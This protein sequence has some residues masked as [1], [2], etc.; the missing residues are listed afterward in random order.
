MPRLKLISIVC[1]DQQDWLGGDEPYLL[2]NGKRVWQA[3][4]VGSGAELSL[5]TVHEIRFFSTAKVELYEQDA[6]AAE[7]EKSAS[8]D[9]L[10]EW[11]VGEN[12]IGKGEQALD[13]KGQ[14]GHYVLKFFV[15]P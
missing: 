14:G 12:L 5:E 4:G 8:D 1:K 6:E 13:F 7:E 11:Q 3:E 9:K 2:V 15:F 10:G